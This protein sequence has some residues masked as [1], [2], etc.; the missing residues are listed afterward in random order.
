MLFFLQ[1]NEIILPGF[2]GG[3]R[4]RLITNDGSPSVV[5][6]PF[7]LAHG[8]GFGGGFMFSNLPFGEEMTYEQLLEL[9][10][11]MGFAYRGATEDQI[12]RLPRS[13]FQE[14]EEKQSS[15]SVGDQP[16]HENGT[17]ST[18]CAICLEDYTKGQ[19]IRT[20]PCMHNFHSAC[21]DKWLLTNKSCPVCKMD[22][23]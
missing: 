6:L 18:T 8:G 5:P 3:I 10:E 19:E 2:G 17:C 9:Q 16:K 21:V 22:I 13:I 7:G 20:L 14:V 11:R 15:A 4:V 12:S 1:V 23:A